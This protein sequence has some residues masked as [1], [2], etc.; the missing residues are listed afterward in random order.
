MT[1]L[2]AV[3]A[4][5]DKISVNG[6]F[7]FWML[8]ELSIAYMKLVDD[9]CSVAMGVDESV[10]GLWDDGLVHRGGGAGGIRSGITFNV[11]GGVGRTLRKFPLFIFSLNALII[12]L[13]L[14]VF[15]SSPGVGVVEW[16][17]NV[18]NFSKSNDFRFCVLNVLVLPMIPVWMLSTGDIVK[19]TL[20]IDSGLNIC[21]PVLVKLLRL[22]A[23]S[24]GVP[25]LNTLPLTIVCWLFVMILCWCPL[26]NVVP[27]PLDSV[28]F[29]ADDAGTGLV[30]AEGRGFA[31]G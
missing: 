26:N 31:I 12:L 27:K 8:V 21:W 7:C 2:T 25:G 28:V 16:F 19:I 4:F 9:I 15:A 17:E 10:D 5:G 20:S 30:L 29:D 24:D 1:T 11:L 6:E 13:L 14:F 18:V 3:F 23:V 22:D